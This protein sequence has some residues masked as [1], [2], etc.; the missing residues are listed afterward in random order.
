MRYYL[1]FAFLTAVPLLAAAPATDTKVQELFATARRCEQARD[2]GCATSHYLA[3]I[4]LRPDLAEVH[5]N[6][7]LVY[8]MQHRD[9]EAILAFQ[10]ALQRKP[11]LLAANL[12][13]GRTL[14]RL[15]RY[16][17]AVAPITKAA[18]LAPKDIDILYDLG[19]AH[20]KSM[21]S[22]YKRM[23]DLDPDSYRV[24]IVLAESY[25][26]R[27]EA[28][29]ALEEY[30][31][32]IKRKPDLPGLHYAAANVAWKNGDLDRAQAGF[33]R[34]LGINPGHHLAVWKL[35]NVHLLRRDAGKALPYLKNAIAL[36]PDLP[37]AHRDL[38]SALIQRGE[39]LE[40]IEHFKKVTE[41]AP[42]ED[43][44]YYRLALAYRKLG[45]K[46]EE[47]Q[48]LAEFA[49]RKRASQARN[50]ISG[51][52]GGESLVEPAPP[53]PEAAP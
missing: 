50:S 49:R 39:V 14:V 44:V 22:A 23:A 53:L 51:V 9:Q 17:E 12:F 18:A 21:E 11:D 2:Y 4:K 19:R 35:G 1:L 47:Q 5:A 33:E 52:P 34:E 10:K 48:A 31:E 27:Q 6:L 20:M 45:R 15:E 26:A 41:L 16:E 3:L 40:A 43:T 32:A 38:G 29:K 46:T 24:H 36:K 28:G 30:E 13:L 37:Q 25:E 42:D 8:Y 7:G